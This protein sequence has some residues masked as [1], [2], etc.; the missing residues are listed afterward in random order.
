MLN[1]YRAALAIRRSDPDL[2]GERFAWSERDPDVLAFRRGDFFVSI[3]N[4]GPS[5]VE[6]PADAE[7]LLASHDLVDGRLPPDAT[8][9]WRTGGPTGGLTS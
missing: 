1:L 7:L 3:T 6:A 8:G 2:R 9:W 4:L 5:G